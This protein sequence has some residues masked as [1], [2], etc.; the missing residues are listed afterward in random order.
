M[1]G[2]ITFVPKIILFLTEMPTKR[3]YLLECPFPR[4]IRPP[5]AKI[6]ASVTVLSVRGFRTGAIPSLA[7][8]RKCLDVGSSPHPHIATPQLKFPKLKLL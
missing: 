6:K 3:N 2:L 5:P 1:N 8:L 4:S 7:T